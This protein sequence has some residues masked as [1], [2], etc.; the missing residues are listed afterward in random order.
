MTELLVY[1]QHGD[2]FSRAKCPAV[3]ALKN[4]SAR[5]EVATGFEPRIGKRRTEFRRFSFYI[6]PL[7]PG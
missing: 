4:D 6:R 7:S 2:E 5:S 1:Q 3:F